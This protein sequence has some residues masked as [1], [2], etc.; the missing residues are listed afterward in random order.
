MDTAGILQTLANAYLYG[1]AGAIIFF[2]L[3]V[4]TIKQNS[5][6][7]TAVSKLEKENTD[8]KKELSENKDKLTDL[9]A[10]VESLN[11]E[12]EEKTSELS[13]VQERLNSAES[14]LNEKTEKINDLETQLKTCQSENADLRSSVSELTTK[15]AEQEKLIEEQNNVMNQLTE[16]VQELEQKTEEMQFDLNI[17]TLYIHMKKL[18]EEFTKD[19]TQ[20]ILKGINTMQISNIDIETAQAIFE[21]AMNSFY[22]VSGDAQSADNEDTDQ[23]AEEQD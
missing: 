2:I 9:E 8:L 17:A 7:S 3:F 1:W 18:Y 14:E 16:K 23:A 22:D 5:A 12:L 10:Q 13:S 6:N 19:Y 4:I 15:T 11:E 21:H 20:N